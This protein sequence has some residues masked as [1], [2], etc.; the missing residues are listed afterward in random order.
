MPDDVPAP[1]AHGLRRFDQAV[2]DLA[3]ADLGNAR[4]ERR[5][6]DGQRHHRGPHAVSGADD[7]PGER[8]QSDHQDQERHRAE[9]V[10][11]CAQSAVQRWRFVDAAL[12]TGDQDHC[13]RNARQQ[14]DQ[15]RHAD[16]QEGVDK[17]LQQAI[18]PHNPVPPPVAPNERRA[19]TTPRHRGTSR[20]PPA[21]VAQAHG[22]ESVPRRLAAI[23]RGLRGR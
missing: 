21:A 8:N 4:K 19:D 16:H 15:R 12:G 1:A 6:G 17:A 20:S 11:E 2:V 13:Q 7:E 5:S 22:P 18:K 23:A 3:Q 14:R 9:Q 10:H